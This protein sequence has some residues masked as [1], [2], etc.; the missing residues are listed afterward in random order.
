LHAKLSKTP[1]INYT[2]KPFSEATPDI[3]ITTPD[4]ATIPDTMATTRAIPATGHP[5]TIT[6]LRMGLLFITARSKEMTSGCPSAKKA[7]QC[8]SEIGL[9]VVE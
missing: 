7:Y 5:T 2:K 9:F 6:P 8:L 4:M 1:K 3:T